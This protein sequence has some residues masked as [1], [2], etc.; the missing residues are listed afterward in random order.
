MQK[1]KKINTCFR[2]INTVST[3][4]RQK[5]HKNLQIRNQVFCRVHNFSICGFFF[6]PSPIC[7]FPFLQNPTIFILKNSL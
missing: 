2:K 7:T 4:Y 6:Y 3:L 1:K 5:H